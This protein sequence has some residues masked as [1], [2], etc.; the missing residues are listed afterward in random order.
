MVKVSS[1]ESSQII[2]FDTI[3]LKQGYIFTINNR[4]YISKKDTNLLIPN[5]VH[6]K[7]SKNRSGNLFEKLDSS[8]QYNRLTRELRNM[9][10]VRKKSSLK[11]ETESTVKSETNFISYQGKVI[12]N[13]NFRQLN[14]FGPTLEDTTRTA[15]SWIER[16]SNKL[17]FKTRE[18]LL[19]NNLIVHEGDLI[20]PLKLADN[21]RILREANYIQDARIYIRTVS[22]SSDSVDLY[23]VVKDV[24]PKAFDLNLNN[25]YSGSF[26][27][28]DKN[29]LGFGHE[30]KNSIFWNTKKKQGLGY[31]GLY[32]I[33]NIGGSFISGKGVYT[34]KFGNETYGI[35]LDRNFFTP[36]VKYAGGLSVYK[37][38]KPDYFQYSDTNIIAPVSFL[39][40]DF[41]LGR[42]FNLSREKDF[43]SR[44]N[45]A[46]AFRVSSTKVMQRPIISE[47]QFYNYQDRSLFLSSVTYSSQS[48]YKSNLIYNYG[49]IEDIP[50]GF[51][52]QLNNGYEVREFS[53]RG[54][55]GFNISYGN[56]YNKLGYFYF[57]IG[58]ESF[59]L[60]KK[61]EQGMITAK[62]NH[63]SA[64]YKLNRFRFR[65]FVDI[66]YT[67]G[68]NRFKDEYLTINDSYGLKGF[69][70]DSIRGMERLNIHTESVCFSPWYLY[71][72]RFVFFASAEF[73]II[74]N[75][76]DIWKNPGYPALSFGVRIRNERLV[77][78]T[79]EL[80]FFVYPNK[81]SYSETQLVR[82]SG[83][84]VL[85]PDN[86]EIKPPT[87]SVFR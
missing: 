23:I 57:W 49:R 42:S 12:R 24:W 11:V 46:F 36:G 32:S 37:T 27:M 86:F 79:I 81:P 71:E 45:L 31:E 15:D 59:L 10:L 19:R 38:T 73:S 1:Q 85:A 52:L 6:Y 72:F 25:L 44:K 18:Y 21:E 43:N 67:K 40:S 53:N 66:E 13:I 84:D 58:H 3:H 5:S 14:V 33:P 69:H 28:W 61:I 55:A 74:G 34:N 60:N 26:T 54:F 17:H 62:F 50:L 68:I 47:N 78:N 80:R 82:F 22:E 65:H 83:E 7:I 8:A 56:Y 9:I 63:F 20:D 29:I 2:K 4:S 64:L 48:F 39:K 35:A 41:W 75:R 30:T 76:K 87:I 51:Q 77:F 16:A 70:N